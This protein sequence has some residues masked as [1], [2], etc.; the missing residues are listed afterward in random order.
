MSKFTEEKL[1]KAI[2]ALLEQ[3][4]FPNTPGGQLQRAPTEVLIKDDLRRFLAGRYAEDKITPAEIEA[5]ITELERLP[6]TGF[7]QSSQSIH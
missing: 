5:V 1:E 6:T 3:R 7:N 2:I 4:G